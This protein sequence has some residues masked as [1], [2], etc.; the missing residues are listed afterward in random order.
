M[1]TATPEHID[2][3]INKQM[4]LLSNLCAQKN[5]FL[6]IFHLPPETLADIFIHGAQCKYHED[7]SSS[8]SCV[9]HWVNVSYVCRH[10]RNVALNCSMLWTYHFTVSLRWTE[11][12]M[13]RSGQAPLKICIKD[14]YHIRLS[15]HHI[16][17]K[18]LDHTER[19]QELCIN[20][21]GQSP[22]SV[23]DTLNHAFRSYTNGDGTL[24]L[25]TLKLY[26][27]PLP[28]SA[29]SL[30]GVKTLFLCNILHPSPQDLVDLLAT[31]IHMQALADLH[32]ENALPSTRSFLSSGEF[33]VSPTFNLPSLACL[34]I[35]APLSTVVT[36][37]SCI[38]VPLKTQLMLYIKS[39]R[40][41]SFHDYAQLPLIFAQRSNQSED[42]SSPSPAIHSLT[43]KFGH[44]RLGYLKF[45]ITASECGSPDLSMSYPPQ[46]HDI[47][48][49]ILVETK[50]WMSTRKMLRLVAD[51]CCTFPSAHVENLHIICPDK[52]SPYFW[53]KTLGHFNGLQHLKLSDG[54]MPHDLVSL[55]SLP[56]NGDPRGDATSDR[57]ATRRHA[58]VP[59]LKGLELCLI[60][61]DEYVN[62]PNAILCALSARK[63]LSPEYIQMTQCSL[64]G[65]NDDDCNRITGLYLYDSLS[66]EY[67]AT[68]TEQ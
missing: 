63:A 30:S 5:S 23:E 62:P 1:K 61:F 58:L 18:V 56:P 15:L 50:P 52:S 26:G 10:W 13:A 36:L 4:I 68:S 40:G 25:H 51:I 14:D 53:K 67:C 47:P 57:H 11:E 21:R 64:D 6:P 42:L 49:V 7:N 46:H 22:H 29:F 3:E 34:F 38:N 54:Y 41:S 19:I 65:S 9:P 32:L 43:I 17:E 20:I 28:S 27:C 24:P 37:L 2:N 12:L 33:N 59:A 39:E 45:T 31:L 44:D 60:T 16:V 48:P 35:A 66:G 8:P 55:L